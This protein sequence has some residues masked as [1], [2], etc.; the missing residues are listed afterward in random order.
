[1]TAGSYG[2]TNHGASRRG[3]RRG[4]L[5][6]PLL[7]LPLGFAIGWV[8]ADLSGGEHSHASST[9]AATTAPATQIADVTPTASGREAV[10]GVEESSPPTPAPSVK[11]VFDGLDFTIS[12]GV[13]GLRLGVATPIRLTLTNPNDVPIYVTL[14]RVDVAPDSTPPGCHAAQNVSVTQSNASAASPIAVPAGSAV[15]L[16]TAPRA[17]QITLLNLPSVNQDVCKGKTF[18]LTYSGSAHS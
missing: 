4:L 15:T 1:V 14:L 7:L 8:S 9:S 5:L 13:S 17:P 2:S 10:G 3:R 16:T 18:T 12:G 11:V 6:L